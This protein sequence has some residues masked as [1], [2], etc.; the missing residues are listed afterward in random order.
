MCPR[1]KKWWTHDPV[2][3]TKLRPW[4]T[5]SSLYFVCL[6]IIFQTVLLQIVHGFMQRILQLVLHANFVQG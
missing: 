1:L 3:P 2:S 4:R 5:V 6:K